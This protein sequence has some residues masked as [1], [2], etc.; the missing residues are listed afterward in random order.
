MSVTTPDGDTVGEVETDARG[1]FTIDLEPGSYEVLAVTG[2]RPPSASPE[3]V[4][5]VADTFTEVTLVVDTGIR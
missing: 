1:G 3:A 2:G 4:V 5:V